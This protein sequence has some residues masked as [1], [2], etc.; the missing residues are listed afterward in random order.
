MRLEFLRL[1]TMQVLGLS[2]VEWAGTG[3]AA[4]HLLR[5]GQSVGIVP[6]CFFF[7]PRYFFTAY[8]IASFFVFYLFCSLYFPVFSLPSCT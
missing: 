4:E 2:T 3:L 1:S 8:C 5:N 7:L 6:L